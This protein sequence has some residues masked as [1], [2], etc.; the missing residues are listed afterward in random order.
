M[1]APSPLQR[2]ARHEDAHAGLEE[3]ARQGELLTALDA[4]ARPAGGRRPLVTREPHAGRVVL[5]DLPLPGR[6]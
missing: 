5:E 4:V 3:G 6:Q 2:G 1:A